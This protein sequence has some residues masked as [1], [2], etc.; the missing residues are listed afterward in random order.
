L[1]DGEAAAIISFCLGNDETTS[2]S[3]V[4]VAQLVESRIVIPVV[5]GSSPI[6]HPKEYAV[7]TKGYMLRLVSLFVFRPADVFII[8][9][10]KLLVTLTDR[11]VVSQLAR[12]T[13]A[14]VG[15]Q[16]MKRVLPVDGHAGGFV[17]DPAKTPLVGD[18]KH[19]ASRV[20]LPRLGYRL[21]EFN[22]NLHSR[23]MQMVV[24][25]LHEGGD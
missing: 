9:T 3:V 6:S 13:S 18:A 12:G 16:H 21:P 4:A 22:R 11:Q 14:T 24:D 17:T 1:P 19:V 15:E 7:K 20:A 2:K 23:L 10:C 8:G 25:R 5:V